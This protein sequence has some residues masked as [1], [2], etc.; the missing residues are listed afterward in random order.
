MG[1]WR[2][3]KWGDR[4]SETFKLMIRATREVCFGMRFHP[5]EPPNSTVRIPGF[6]GRVL[7]LLYE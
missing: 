6:L 7:N 1:V 4:K 3:A 2:A 5:L